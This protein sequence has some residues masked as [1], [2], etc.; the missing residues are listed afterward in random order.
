MGYLERLL[1][2]APNQKTLK[3]S[4][5]NARQEKAGRKRGEGTGEK[6][7]KR[8][9]TVD[10]TD[11]SGCIQLTCFLQKPERTAL[12]FKMTASHLP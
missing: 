5:K 11:S 12:V 3:Q 6:T 8:E 10:Q 9:K 4:N 7:G 1:Q 2:K